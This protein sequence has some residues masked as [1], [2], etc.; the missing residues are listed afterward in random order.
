MIAKR[1]EK[2]YKQNDISMSIFFRWGSKLVLVGAGI[3]FIIGMY[4]QLAALVTILVSVVMILFTFSNLRSQI[5][6]RMVWFLLLGASLS[7]F[8]T[9]AGVLAIDLPI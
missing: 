5:P 8:I 7:L 3:L 1:I 4:T 2:A 6:D 9:G